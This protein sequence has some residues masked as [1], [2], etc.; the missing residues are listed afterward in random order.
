MRFGISLA[1]G[2]I[3]DTDVE[4]CHES[5]GDVSRQMILYCEPGRKR[6]RSTGFLLEL[7]G[8]QVVSVQGMEEALNWLAV[9]GEQQPQPALILV[10][11]SWSEVGKSPFLKTL[12]RQDGL[13]PLLVLDVQG[14]LA[15]QLSFQGETLVEKELPLAPVQSLVASILGDKISSRE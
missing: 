8:Y 3:Q 1:L 6:S 9:Y 11:G 13:R 7:A 4:R 12:C 10:A 5:R 15:K 14:G 2:N